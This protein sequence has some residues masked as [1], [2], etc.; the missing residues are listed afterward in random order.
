MTFLSTPS[1]RRATSPRRGAS[2][3]HGHF[4]PRPP[5][6]GRPGALSARTPSA[7]Y[8]YPRPPRGGRLRA[9]QIDLVGEAISI[10]ALREEGDNNAASRYILDLDISIHALREEGDCFSWL[11]PDFCRYFYPRPPR[12]GRLHGT[13][14]L[15]N[16][17]GYFYP[18][19]P[20]GGRPAGYDF[21]AGLESISIHALREEGDYL[22]NKDSY[23]YKG[24]LSTPSARRATG[25]IWKWVNGMNISIHALREEG[26]CHHIRVKS[27]QRDFYPRPPRGGRRKTDTGMALVWDISIHALREEG[28]CGAQRRRPRLVRDF[29]P[30]PPRGGRPMLHSLYTGIWAFLS[31]PSA[32]RATRAGAASESVQRFLSTPSARRATAE[33]LQPGRHLQ[34][35]S[36][37]SARRATLF[38]RPCSRWR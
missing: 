11:R 23:R 19:P 20:R 4:Y 38:I 27:G 21:G 36:T 5:R 8:F 35:L 3:R 15:C 10:H 9:F 16:R 26:D 13:G 12:G 6:G 33:H 30:R 14:G 34:F 18:R 37:P 32:R 22:K 1:A 25:N 24:F 29:Y 2:R 7:R 28:D 17:S 31:T